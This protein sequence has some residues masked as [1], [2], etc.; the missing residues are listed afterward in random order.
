MRF[1][2]FQIILKA[3]SEVIILRAS[4]NEDH[5]PKRTAQIYN[6]LLA[7]GKQN[8]VVLGDLNDTP[9]NTGPLADLLNTSLK[10]VSTHPTFDPGEFPQIG[11][12]GLGNNSNKIDYLLLSPN[13]FSKVQSSGLFRKGAY[14][15]AS[16]RW[17]VYPTLTE[18]VHAG[19]DHHVIWADINI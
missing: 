15:G 6:D 13:L 19:S 8:I 16:P 10:D 12:Y 5:R 3:N 11:T 4:Q 9:D 2:S 18:K 14:P 17:T 1:G 7:A